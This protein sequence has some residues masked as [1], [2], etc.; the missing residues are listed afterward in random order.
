LVL[1]GFLL[2]PIF[3]PRFWMVL[4]AAAIYSGLAVFIHWNLL[5]AIADGNG[6]A[7]PGIFDLLVPALVDGAVYL[8]IA[9]GNLSSQTPVRSSAAAPT[10]EHRLRQT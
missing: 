3:V 2:A 7:Q 6:T 10:L 4:L 8:A 1:I 5:S 9:L